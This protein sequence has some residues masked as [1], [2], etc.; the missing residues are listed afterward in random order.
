MK[1]L[2]RPI[3]LGSGKPT[4]AHLLIRPRPL[5][6]EDLHHFLQRVAHANRL[7]GIYR[8]LGT[9]GL[10]FHGERPTA[11]YE[12]LGRLLNI[13]PGELQ[14]MDIVPDRNAGNRQRFCYHGHSL[15]VHHLHQDSPRICTNCLK[16]HGSGQ[17]V[18]ALTAMTACP[19]HEALLVDACPRCD[20][21]LSWRRHDMF[22]CPCGCDLREFPGISASPV[23]VALCRRIAHAFLPNIHPAVHTAGVPAELSSL[24]LPDLLHLVDRLGSHFA[25]QKLGVVQP[26][27]RHTAAVRHQATV[28]A[29]VATIL[30]HWPDALHQAL[31]ILPRQTS[32]DN[33]LWSWKRFAQAHCEFFDYA[34]RQNVPA[35]LRQATLQY[36]E[37]HRIAGHGWERYR[38]P[39][40]INLETILNDSKLLSSFRKGSLARHLGISPNAVNRLIDSDRI[41]HLTPDGIPGGV[42]AA[43]KLETL[44]DEIKH[45]VSAVDAAKL[46]GI[47]RHQFACLAGAG[48]VKPV[49]GS[50]RGSQYGHYSPKALQQLIEKVRGHRTS[51]HAHLPAYGWISLG[52]LYPNRPRP[53]HRFSALVKAIINGQLQAQPGESHQGIGS[54]RIQPEQAI[55]QGLYFPY[56]AR[57]GS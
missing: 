5:A 8:V 38:P 56:H 39:G 50:E 53:N 41:E 48:L 29:H 40:M 35:F 6:E 9:R 46:L 54:L 12:T 37:V 51:S 47:N 26:G 4:Q 16:E 14:H 33:S 49:Y 17:A 23:S 52:Q 25:A 43:E 55:R 24:P 10:T 20:R 1:S 27:R 3:S 11:W 22:R 45:A 34:L 15:H 2:A 18:W 30:T 44:A 36:I 7:P 28:T 31:E 42:F 57:R 13:P 19:E 32:S 21:R